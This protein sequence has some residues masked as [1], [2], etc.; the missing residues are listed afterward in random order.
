MLNTESIAYTLKWHDLKNHS[1]PGI[2]N[3]NKKNIKTITMKHLNV[4]HSVDVKS[5]SA[6]VPMKEL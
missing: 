5:S 1:I 6:S 2:F 3:W 4:S